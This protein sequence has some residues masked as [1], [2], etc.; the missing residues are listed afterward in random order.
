MTINQIIK[1]FGSLYKLSKALGTCHKTPYRWR[2][3]DYIP[4]KWQKKIEDLTEGKL[5]C[6]LINK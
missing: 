6:K 3:N 4:L 5:K 1:H 2:D